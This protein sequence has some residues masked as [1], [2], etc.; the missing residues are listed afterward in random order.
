MHNRRNTRR[1][2]RGG[3][4]PYPDSLYMKQNQPSYGVMKWSVD[5]TAEMPSAAEMKYVVA[6][7]GSRRKHRRGKRHHTCSHKCK[8]GKRSHKRSHK[9]KH[10]KR[11]KRHTRR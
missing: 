2:S 3:M 9:C 6:R 1:S 5:Q 8:H 10:G 11:S 4:A 7:G